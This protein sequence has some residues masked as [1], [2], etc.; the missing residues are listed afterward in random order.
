MQKNL[1]IEKI[2]FK[3]VQIKSYATYITNHFFL[4]FDIF[5]AVNLLNICMEHD[6]YLI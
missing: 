5:T 4:R 1:N 2:A 3:D 6:L